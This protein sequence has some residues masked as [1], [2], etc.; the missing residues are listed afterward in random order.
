M[1]SEKQTQ[2]AF[3]LAQREALSTEERSAFSAAICRHLTALPALQAAQTILSYRSTE[4]EVDLS[5]FHTWAAEQGKTLA[6]PVSYPGGRMEAYVPQGPESWERGRYGIW[7]PIPERSK[8]MPPEQLDAVILPCVGFDSQGW[9]LGHGGGYYDRYLPL[10]PR[11]E[12]ILVAFETQRL[13]A[14]AT[15]VHDQNAHMMVTELGDFGLEFPF[16]NSTTGGKG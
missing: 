4:T 1:E 8:R 11:A 12:R 7:A 15:D 10:C 5:A 9:R 13:E 2:R 6:F 3:A 16:Q 14:V